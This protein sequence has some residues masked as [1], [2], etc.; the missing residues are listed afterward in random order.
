MTNIA[1][2]D[3]ARVLRET[4]D[5]GFAGLP[6]ERTDASENY[7]GIRIGGDAFALKLAEI[8]GLFAGR[9]IV[10]L[11]APYAEILGVVSLRRQIVPV[12]SLRAFL[13]YPVSEAPPRWIALAGAAVGFAFDQ[14]DFH[15]RL[16]REQ[17]SVGRTERGHIHSVAIIAGT[18]RP[19]ISIPSILETIARRSPISLKEH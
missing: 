8:T 9:Q 17:I 2:G 19:I 7:L 18:Q 1:V 6:A 4:F 13:N 10:S 16:A 5:A 15:A 12:Y 14:F 3:K 11:P